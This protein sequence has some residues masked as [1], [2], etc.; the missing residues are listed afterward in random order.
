MTGTFRLA[1]ARMNPRMAEPEANAARLRALRLRAASLGADLVLAP[2][3]SLS[4]AVPAELAADP[5][6]AAALGVALD[7]LAAEPGPPLILGAPWREGDRLR[8]GLHLL[9]GGAVRTRRAAHELR[10]GFDPGPVPGPLGFGEIRLGLMAGRDWRGPMVAETL[11]ETGAEILL[12]ADSLPVETGGEERVLQSALARVVENGLPLVLL[13]RLGAEGESA[14]DGSALV[15]NADRAP[16]LRAR[17][18]EE[19]VILTEWVRDG[20]SWR[21]LPVL[22]PAP[23]PEAERIWRALLLALRDHAARHAPA[24]ILLPLERGADAALLAA[25]AAEAF[26]AADLRPLLMEGEA[27][28]LARNL[29]LPARAP[30]LAPA[31]AALSAALGLREDVALRHLRRLA[32]D[33]LAEAEGLLPLV[34]GPSEVPS[35][36]APLWHLSPALRRDLA[37]WRGIHSPAGAEGVPAAPE[38]LPPAAVAPGPPLPAPAQSLTPWQSLARKDYKRRHLPPGLNLAPRAFGPRASGQDRRDTETEDEPA[39]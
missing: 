6:F 17:P 31:A 9:E 18:F 19:G 10:P 8:E 4:G 36:F 22:A 26:P 39:P 28:P 2:E 13:N 32:L 25:L 37:A 12:A 3:H 33:A 34:A 5:A 23:M 16:A 21:C 7:G 1:L 27:A 20:A 38:R 29:G 35:A 11:A 14:H 30:D 24:G 15:L